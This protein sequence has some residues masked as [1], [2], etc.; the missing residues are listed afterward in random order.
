MDTTGIDDDSAAL[1]PYTGA[2]AIATRDAVVNARTELTRRRVEL[3]R[4]QAAQRAELDRQ[5]RELE[6]QF[7]KARTD[8]MAQMAPL[9]DQLK[10]MAEV[11]WTVDL[12][13][14]RDE[15]LQLIRD[16]KPADAGTPITLRQKVLVMAEESL[17]LMGGKATGMTSDDIPE[18]I[19]WLCA[20]DAHLDRVLP[21]QKGVVVLIPTRVQSRSGNMFED[22][23]RDAANQ[24]SYWLLRN[25]ERLYLLTVDPQLRIFDRVLPRRREFVEVFEEKVFGL[26][27]SKPVRPGSDEWFD[28]EQV[29]DARRRHYMR[30]MLVLQGIVDRTPVW[31]PLPSAGANFMSIKDQDAGRIVLIQDDEDSIQLG[32]GGETFAQWQ[33][34][35]NALLRPGLRVIG[36]WNTQAFRDL[37]VDVDWWSRGNPPRLHPGTIYEYPD[38]DVPHLIEDRRD[39]G[40][41]I[42]YQRTEKIYKRN[43]PVPDQP[44][45]LY[46][47]ETAVEP[48]QRASCVVRTDDSWVLPYDLVT[49]P[50]LEKF[51]YSRDERSRHFL[52]MVPTVRA[53]L[54][55]K[56]AEAAQEAEFRDL[57]GRLLIMEGAEADG[58][59]E[60][61]DDLVHWWK[62]AHTWSKPLNGTGTHEK[63]AA[64]QIVV[65]YRARRRAQADSAEETIVS[66]GRHLPGVI[67]VARDRQGRWNAYAPSPDAHE[68]GIYLDVTRIRR[69]GALG[70]TTTWQILTQRTV[71][72][73]HVAWSAPDWDD[74][75][76]GANP[77]H[78]LTEP[79]WQ[80][81][82]ALACERTKGIPIAVTEQWDP[83][84]PDKRGIFVYSWNRATPPRDT[85]AEPLRDALSWH[86]R[87]HE[88][89]ASQGFLVSAGAEG[90]LDL[91]GG[92]FREFDAPSSFSHYSGG[93]KWGATPWWPDDATKYS[94]HRPRL[95]WADEDMLDELADYRAR[96]AALAD[97]R[98]AARREFEAAAQ[99]YVNP[100]MQLIRTRQIAVVRERFE[101]DYGRDADDLWDAHLKS[102]NLREPIHQRE[103]WGIVAIALQQGEPVAGRTLQDLADNARAH[104]N[105][106]P[107]EWHPDRNGVSPGEYSDIVVP[108]P[109]TTDA[110]ES[111]Q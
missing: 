32:E 75:T 103:I 99:Q 59:G 60:L 13:L 24:R 56:H 20:D 6:A 1:V 7:E 88:A 35:L 31:H 2:D 23:S 111:A 85:T 73:L 71:S 110:E 14:G 16:G 12:Y 9:Q 21:E 45:W 91:T 26:R 70:K 55:A 27:R 54:A 89:V 74:W 106:A 5:R 98:D 66:A 29:A 84:R 17:I 80:A 43:Q 102:L 30:I 8:L 92:G 86:N 52:D 79:S 94:D 41:V 44:G 93:S 61:V 64:D 104:G 58:I 3:E 11:L 49:V 4:Q 90:V 68:T 46:R 76:F 77:R 50:E 48:K 10:K 65:E 39:G 105:N 33:R 97:E 47:G 87:G 96:C 19:D 51:L 53:A 63:K 83:R 22:V 28:L 37:Y 101:E 95:I 34:R 67:A 78:H 36:N 38:T 81:L 62:L 69:N 15:T 109:P 57:I 72:A 100:V 107:G 40:L 42:R 82:I 18:F 25:G 108:E